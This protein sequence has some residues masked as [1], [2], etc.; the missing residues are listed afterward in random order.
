MFFNLEPTGGFRQLY[1]VFVAVG[2]LS[3]HPGDLGV[4]H[5]D[6]DVFRLDVGV[7][8]FAHVVKI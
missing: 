4:F 5:A 2:S 3:R 6:E 1:S 8:N 7:D